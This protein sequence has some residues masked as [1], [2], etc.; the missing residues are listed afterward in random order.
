MKRQGT[1]TSTIKIISSVWKRLNNRRKFQLLILLSCMVASSFSELVS[2]GAVVPFLTILS[3]PNKIWENKYITYI[4]DL[5]GITSSNELILLAVIGLGITVTISGSIR[6]I[7]L[8]VSNSLAAKIGCDL[9]CEAYQKTIYQPYIFHTKSNSSSFITATTTQIAKTVRALGTFLQVVSSMFVGAGIIIG[10]MVINASIAISA[11]VLLSCTYLLLSIIVRKRLR[12]NSIKIKRSEESQIK[13]LQEGFGSIR[14]ILLHDEQKEY[15]D[16]YTGIDKPLRKLQ[17]ENDFLGGFPKYVIE[18]IGFIGIFSLGYILV[19]TEGTESELIPTIG[20]F[21]MGAQRLLPALQQIYN[22]WARIKGA[23]ESINRVISLTNL[24]VPKSHEK[25]NKTMDIETYEMENIKFRYDDGGPY[26]LN[27]VNIKINKN[28]R[29]GIVG[30][31]G[32][33]K[34]TFTDLI[35]GLLEPNSGTIYV[36]GERLNLN[37][38]K[39]REMW[40]NTISHVPQEVYLSD[41]TIAENIARE[42]SIDE[43]NMEKL[44]LSAKKANIHSFIESMNKGYLSKA[45][46]QGIQLSGGQKQRIGIARALYRDTK[47]LVLDE[48]TSALDSETE[49]EVMNAIEGLG[50]ELIIVIVAHKRN[51]LKLCNKIMEVKENTI[52]EIPAPGKN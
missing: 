30:K 19:V 52:K 13:L 42:P 40:Q 41:K 48:A 17:A 23:S 29:V 5:V 51:T 4:A 45:G 3:N 31:T 28:D 24:K 34:T 18:T 9:S 16:E 14:D 43:I 49:E 7:N 20:A 27:N 26:L 50:D 25:T 35:L 12:R 15:V 33:G 8:W 38:N 2:L 21:A 11:G 47:V 6:L 10:L 46:E 32:S 22:G 44:Y 36:N 39:T 1:E 37:D